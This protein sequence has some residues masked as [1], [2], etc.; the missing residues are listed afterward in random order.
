MI[1]VG[2]SYGG[3]VVTEAGGHIPGAQHLV[4]LA[5]NPGGTPSVSSAREVEGSIHGRS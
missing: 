4:Y 2:H 5:G 1:L 3:A